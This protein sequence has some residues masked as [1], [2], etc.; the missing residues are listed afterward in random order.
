MKQANLKLHWKQEAKVIASWSL[1]EY[2]IFPSYISNV[3][4]QPRKRRAAL[5][6]SEWRKS[7]GGRRERASISIHHAGWGNVIA[8]TKTESLSCLS[9]TAPFPSITVPGASLP[10]LI[11]HAANNYNHALLLETRTCRRSDSLLRNGL[12]LPVHKNVIKNWG[13]SH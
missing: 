2:D 13:R 1:T 8:K 9:F 4:A 10:L 12:H 6:V 5:R 7:C 11:Y 3:I